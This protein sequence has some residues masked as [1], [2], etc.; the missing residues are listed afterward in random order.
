MAE[1]RRHGDAR[2]FAWGVH[3]FTSIGVVLAFLALLAVERQQSREAL[4]WLFAA[5]V[6]DGIDGTLARAAK[7]G[8]RLP[9]I[10]G[11]ALDLVIDYLSYVF[12][13]ALFIW[14]GGYLPEAAALPFI[15]AILASSLYVFARR[16]MKTE[17][18]YFRGFP[19]LWNVVAFYFFVT[20]P[21]PAICALAVAALIIMTFAPVHVAHPFRVREYGWIL[22]ALSILWALSTAALLLP[23]N[24]VWPVLLTT[25]LIT[26]TL[27]V[28]MGLLR[29]VRGARPA[30]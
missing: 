4:L 2:T 13:P 10:D 7:V 11:E 5:L 25:S 14:H 21:D 15:A 12:V 3:L 8:E 27:V 9:R 28:G 18:G 20:A 22:P 26:A 24:G 16:D 30:Q 19:A 17:D 1:Q 6:I 23:P 29:T